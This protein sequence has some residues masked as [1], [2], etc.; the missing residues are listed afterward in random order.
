MSKIQIADKTFQVKIARGYQWDCPCEYCDA[1]FICL[2]LGIPK[3]CDDYYPQRVY[4][5]R[6]YDNNT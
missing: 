1:E 2:S 5:K 4:L 3:L 6:V